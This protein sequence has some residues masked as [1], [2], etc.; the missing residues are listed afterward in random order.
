MIVKMAN[1]KH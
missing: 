1:N